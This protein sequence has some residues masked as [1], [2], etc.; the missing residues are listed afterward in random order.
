MY[1]YFIQM[2]TED[3]FDLRRFQEAQ[4]EIFEQ[5]K[6]ELKQGKKQTHWMWFIFPQLKALGRSDTSKFYGIE[7]KAEAEAFYK[8]PILGN[9]LLECCEILKSLKTTD[10]HAIF[11]FPDELKLKSCLTLFGEA[12]AENAFFESLLQHY[13]DGNKDQK[14]LQLLSN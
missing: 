12:A 10:A 14:T 2:Q 9:R 8:H 6:V 1:K 7:S 4:E 13:F 11:G 3:E 5:V